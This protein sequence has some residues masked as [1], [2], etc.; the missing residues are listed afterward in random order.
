MDRSRIPSFYKMSVEDRVR[1]MR[2][3]GLL[4]KDDYEALS[5]GKAVLDVD[6]ADKMIENVIGVMGLP[7]G[8]GLNFL[9]NGKD[10]V[11]P[12][13]VEEPSIVAA[14]SSAAKTV[15]NAGG[16]EASS[17]DP[18]LIGQVQVVEV[19]HVAKAQAAILQ[20]KEE[21]LNLANS[22][23]PKMVARGGGAKDLEVHIHPS[24]YTKGDMLVVHLL[25]DT[26]DAMGA[27]L[28]NTMCEGVASLVE[29]ITGG[30]VFLRILSNLADRSLARAKCVIPTKLLA[31]GGF[32]GEQV[33]DG[34]IIA[35]EFA[36]VDPYRAVTHNKGVMNGVDAVALATGNDWRAIEASCHAWAARS[37]RYSS[38]T[39]WYKDDEGNLVGE[40]ELPLKVGIVGG[41]LQS[42]PSVAL[43]QRLV[44]VESAM[45]LAELMAVVGL[46]QNFSAIRALSTEGIQQG[47]MTLHAR[48]VAIT[49]GAT[50]DIFD[51]VV[52]RLVESGEIK[53]W[54]A[55]EI[56][57]EL[58]S[59]G[60]PEAQQEK[61]EDRT[62]AEEETLAAGYGKIILLGEHSVVYGRHAIAAPIP[63]AIQSKVADAKAGEGVELIIP[64]WGVEQRLPRNP[65][66]RQA[67]QKQF[68]LILE[69]LGLEDRD[70]KIEIFPN[71]PRAMG[72]GGSAALAVAAIRA[73]DRHYSLGLSDNDVNA[74]AFECEKVAHGT[75]SGI[76]NTMATYGRPLLFRKGS[77]GLQEFLEIPQPV[78]FVVGITGRE[79]LTHKMVT[80]VRQ[81]WERNT[82]LYERIFNEIDALTLQGVKALGNH[83]LEQ[84]GDLMN[85]CQG[86]LNA[87]QVSSWDIEEL[88]QIARDNG[89]LGAKL[90]GGGGGGS[91]IALA[92]DNPQK[93]I[94]AMRDAGYQ[95]ME[96][97][98]GG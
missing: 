20:R 35:N 69:K 80:R 64:R 78:N 67:F 49:A 85:V 88:V 9:V 70:M 56:I 31:K 13:T 52:D 68:G 21:I 27:N 8:L 66:Q 10:Y 63:L 97:S 74:L 45:E 55:R 43:N 81:Q 14:L 91:M 57:E 59:Q 18:I 29:N 75:P 86:L 54:K 61:S 44:N 23:H 62:A 7:T 98:V 89:A 47:H 51:I 41:S 87:L 92:P 60:V 72:L 15:R 94:D 95:A 6:A 16:F 40:I 46:A 96:V 50:A 84:L 12:L 93:I 38:L 34:I 33:R 58:Q 83:D 3:R 30:K 17:T 73:L 71:V 26:R 24:E 42:N 5:S 36:T 37:G 28:V 76:D 11:V 77:P 25:V 22:L 19:P 79:T 1:V 48:S 53:T 4:T 2:E 32:D 90:T 82:S 65:E 39:R